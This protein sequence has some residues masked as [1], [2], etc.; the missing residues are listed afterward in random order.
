M[1]ENQEVSP[2]ELSAEYLQILDESTRECLVDLENA[3]CVSTGTDKDGNNVVVLIPSVLFAHSKDYDTQL[4]RLLLLFVNKAHHIVQQPY[5]LVYAHTNLP[6]FSQQRIVFQIHKMLPRVYKKNLA[7]LL[8]VHPTFLIKAFFEGVRWFISDKFYKKLAFISTIAELQSIIP[9]DRIPLPAPFLASEDTQKGL[10]PTG[11]MTPLHIC[12]DA[13]LGT[14]PLISQCMHYIRTH[15]EGL[16]TPG[17]FRLAGDQVQ[18]DLVKARLYG[19]PAEAVTKYVRIGAGGTEGDSPAV[20]T[21]STVV[22]TDIHTVASILKMSLR[23]LEEPLVTF[24]V[25]A[26][27]M[28]LARR[29]QGDGTWASPDKDSERTLSELLKS[30]PECN[31][32]TLQHLLRYNCLRLRLLQYGICGVGLP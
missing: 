9:P 7:K 16:Q 15:D 12:Y 27:L 21:M 11:M 3:G 1:D 26:D 31:H 2:P 30:M 25:Y 14:T 24:T 20:R 22:I 10:K 19:Q 5:T 4:R 6:I 8:V 32:H 18:E 13:S 23:D 28:Q 17:L 29:L